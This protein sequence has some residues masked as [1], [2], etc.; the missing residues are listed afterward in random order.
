[1]NI[2]QEV[3]LTLINAIWAIQYQYL[4]VWAYSINI[5][6]YINH[7]HT[8]QYKVY[9][10]VKNLN[11]LRHHININHGFTGSAVLRALFP[12]PSLRP[13]SMPA[14]PRSEAFKVCA[15]HQAQPQHP[16]AE[17]QKIS[18]V[19]IPSM[20]RVIYLPTWMVDFYGKLVYR[21]L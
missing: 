4:S 8:H 16:E 5:S 1:M 15:S 6:I 17:I 11:I 13:K 19:P 20:G 7:T 14:A 10:C 18:L 2:H 3:Q 21:A 9:I 12:E